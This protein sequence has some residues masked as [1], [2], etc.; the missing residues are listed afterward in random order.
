MKKNLL[1]VTSIFPNP[2]NMSLGTYNRE[3]V[4]ELSEY[5]DIDVIVP[6]PWTKYLRSG[7][8]EGWMLRSAKVHH[9]VYYYPPGSFHHMHDFFYYISIRRLVRELTLSKIYCAVLGTWLY[10]DSRVA[11]KIAKSLSIPYFVKVHGTDVNRLN[12]EHK[13]FS[14]SMDVLRSA[15]RVFCVSDGLKERLESLGAPSEN[16]LVIRNGINKLIFS[17]CS[18]ESSRQRLELPNN[19]DIILFVGNLKREKGLYELFSAFNKIINM[20][21][22]AKSRLYL[23]GEGPFERELHQ[24]TIQQEMSDSVVFLGRKT[25]SD[26]ALWMNAASLLCLPSYSEGMPNVVLE[27]LSCNTPV[28]ATSIDGIIELARQDDRIALVPP[29]EVDSLANVII[30]VLGKGSKSSG[31]LVINNWAEYAREVS[32][33]IGEQAHAGT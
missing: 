23:I 14:L 2:K 31:G 26:V 27:A 18:I 21:T 15:S 30:S 1:I 3:L 20:S 5:F 8:S 22:H 4:A 7:T 11:K 32:Q 6:I 25:P 10:P 9:P 13:L 17:P 24:Y 19:L 29:R 28:V 16:L 12:K 33:V